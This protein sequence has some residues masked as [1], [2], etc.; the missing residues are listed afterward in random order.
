[1]ARADVIAD[2]IAVDRLSLSYGRGAERVEAL[3]EVS[4]RI[5][6]GEFV[7]VVGPSGCGKST[8]LKIL[9]GLLPPSGGVAELA[10]QP[11]A[12]PRRDIGVVFQTPVL[13][14]WRTV[15]GN[16]L[17]PAD[18]QR[19]D[20]AAM[21]RRA[22]ELLGLV[23]LAGFERRYPRELSGGMQ[24]RVGIVR[25]LLHDPAI[26][27]MDEPFGALDAMT[28]EAMTVE[29]QRIWLERRTTV[30]FITH[31]TAEA[32]FLADRVIVLTARPG[33]IGDEF[34]VDLPRPRALE[35][36]NTERFGGY[37]GRVRAA[38]HARAGLE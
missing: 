6:D 20:R 34:A 7:V 8:L 15:I 12:G 32:V 11:I 1:M 35:V 27:L 37:V 31:S 22:Q 16:A 13:L 28:R 33:T 36:M 18:V 9:A 38:L 10:G 24:Q 5:G 3:R 29:L 23:G 21:T 19:L 2:V 25:A 4:F 14:P 17:L 30:L 26:L